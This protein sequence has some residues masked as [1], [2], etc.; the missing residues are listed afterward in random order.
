MVMVPLCQEEIRHG[1]SGG[2]GG[3]GG[4]HPQK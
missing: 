1:F 2:G 4:A 3:G